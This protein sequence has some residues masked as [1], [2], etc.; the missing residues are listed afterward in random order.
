[1]NKAQLVELVAEKTKTTK[2]QSELILDATLEAIQEALKDGEEVKLV[3]FGTFTRTSRK[4]RQGRNP[5]TGETVKI[6]SAYI[7]KFKPGK[8]LKDALN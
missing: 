4:A 7:P 6:P 3:G 2:T 5:K 1:M 8:D